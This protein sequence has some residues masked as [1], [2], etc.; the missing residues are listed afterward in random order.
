MLRGRR[1]SPGG[2]KCVDFSP[3]VGS[4]LLGRI[5]G[6]VCQLYFFLRRRSFCQPLLWLAPYNEMY[7]EEANSSSRQQGL[8]AAW[9]RATANMSLPALLDA[10]FHQRPIVGG[11]GTGTSDGAG[12]TGE[13]G[14]AVQP[15]LAASATVGAF[16]AA[17]VIQS[18]MPGAGSEGGAEALQVRRGRG[19]HKLALVDP[20]GP[21]PHTVMMS[22]HLLLPSP[23]L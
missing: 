18:L 23:S 8:S 5:S 16:S 15:A 17:A 2:R 6:V 14:G 13:R 19:A 4:S 10:A 7:G 21:I 22:E 9:Q 3:Y 20:G 12:S 11:G 1:A